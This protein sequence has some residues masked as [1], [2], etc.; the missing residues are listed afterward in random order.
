MSPFGDY[1]AEPVTFLASRAFLMVV[2]VTVLLAGVFGDPLW[3]AL[4]YGTAVGIGFA[5]TAY[6]LRRVLD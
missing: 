2:V 6:M 1:E 4:V 5:L 3:F